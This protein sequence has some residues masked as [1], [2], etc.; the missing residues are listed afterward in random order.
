MAVHEETLRRLE[1]RG[2]FNE[3]YED[4]VIRLLETA[5][6]SAAGSGQ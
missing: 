2:Q 6:S 1:E 5:G 3:S 4:V